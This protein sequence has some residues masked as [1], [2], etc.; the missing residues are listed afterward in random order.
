[1]RLSWN[2]LVEAVAKFAPRGGARNKLLTL[3]SF[4]LVFEGLSVLLLFSYDALSLGFFSMALG[5]FILLVLGSLPT[6]KP[7]PAKAAKWVRAGALRPTPGI[8]LVDMIIR[9]IGG[10]V[11]LMMIG[12]AIIVFVVIYNLRFSA[13]PEFG[14]LDTLSLM[15]GGMLMA[16]PLLAS[17]FKTEAVFCLMFLSL[18]VLFLVIP[19]F[20]VSV[21]NDA[22]SSLGNSYVHYMLAAPFAGILDLIGI[23]ASSSG[24]MVTI[25]FHDG[26]SNPLLISA[27]CAGMYSFSIFVSAFIAFVLVFETFPRKTTAIVLGVGLLAAYLGNLFRMVIIG[28]VGYYRGMESLRWAH[29]NVG[30]IIFLSW[31]CV[32][33]FLVMRYADRAKAREPAG[34]KS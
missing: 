24:N 12:A 19:Q 16:Y 8:K 18:V 21:S 22:S 9:G 30:W 6:G 14:D 17:K 25:T 20:V 32:F 28:I 5:G 33:W 29:A 13:N 1:M 34:E 31:S 3:V 2:A 7:V 10:Y 26:T 15:L 4:I 11:P 23:P 27:Y